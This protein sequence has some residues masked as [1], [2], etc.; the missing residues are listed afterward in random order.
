M[1]LPE[2]TRELITKAPRVSCQERTTNLAII[3]AK[4]QGQRRKFVA[5]SVDA[6]D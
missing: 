2:K 4:C 5:L 6:T 3:K 1:L